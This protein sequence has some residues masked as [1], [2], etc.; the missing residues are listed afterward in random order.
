MDPY[1]WYP[2]GYLY[3]YKTQFKDEKEEKWEK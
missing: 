3:M 1:F 2:I